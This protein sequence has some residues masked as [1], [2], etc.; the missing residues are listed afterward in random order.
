MYSI[1]EFRVWHIDYNAGIEKKK[2]NLNQ[3]F[4]IYLSMCACTVWPKKLNQ[5][6]KPNRYAN[7][8]I[9]S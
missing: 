8:E 3:L 1:F 7:P 6:L 4:F 9:D 2:R 5:N